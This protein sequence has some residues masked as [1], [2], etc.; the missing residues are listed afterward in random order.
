M[1][2]AYEENGYRDRDDYLHCLSDDYGVR[3]ETVYA[4]AYLFGSIE[5]FDGLVIALEDINQ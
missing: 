2:N 4:L 3:L 5:D 1:S